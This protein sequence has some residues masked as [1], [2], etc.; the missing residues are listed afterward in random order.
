[1]FVYNFLQGRDFLKIIENFRNI[2]SMQD[3]YSLG[4][5]DICAKL[6]LTYAVKRY[7]SLLTWRLYMS[8][9][10]PDN[11]SWTVWVWQSTV[12][13]SDRPVSR[14]NFSLLAAS[15]RTNSR[16]PSQIFGVEFW[17]QHFELF[18]SSQTPR[19]TDC[20]TTTLSVTK[21]LRLLHSQNLKLP[22]LSVPP[23][24]GPQ[25]G[26]HQRSPEGNLRRYSLQCSV[27][28]IQC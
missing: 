26:C 10:P 9:Y 7:L 11:T 13:Q 22:D 1:M 4:P 15:S 17:W 28:S 12:W 16:K 6:V 23:L 8:K 19:L 14:E 20:N 18:Q 25:S 5:A 27:F 21:T 24:L 2:A 3:T